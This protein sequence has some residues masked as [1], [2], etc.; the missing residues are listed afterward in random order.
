MVTWIPNNDSCNCRYAL[1][2]F[3]VLSVNKYTAVNLQ[4]PAQIIDMKF[5]TILLTIQVVGCAAT[6]INA[7]TDGSRCISNCSALNIKSTKDVKI[8][9]S[10]IE[11]PS[12]ISRYRHLE[13]KNNW[14]QIIRSRRPHNLSAM[15]AAAETSSSN[16]RISKWTRRPLRTKRYRDH[17]ARDIG[18]RD[19]CRGFT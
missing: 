4:E 15:D 11:V 16:S 3:W 5:C 2:T 14:A 9:A 8:N 18:R 17:P 13:F 6:A 12:Y 7:L 1:P 10:F 19:H